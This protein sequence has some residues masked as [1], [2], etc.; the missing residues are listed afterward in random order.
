MLPQWSHGQRRD[1]PALRPR[2]RALPASAGARR[3]RRAPARRRREPLRRAAAA[4]GAGAQPAQA[5]RQRARGDRRGRSP[6]SSRRSRAL[7]LVLPKLKLLTTSGTALVSVAA[8]SLFWGWEFAAGFVVLLFLH[9]MGHVIAL[10]REGIKASAPMFIP[11]LGAAIF[12][13]SL[14]DNALAEARVG[15]AGP[16]LGTPRRGRGRR[17]RRAHRQ[18]VPARAGLRRL[19]HQPVQPAAGRAARRRAGDGGDGAVDVV[20]RLRRAGRDG[21]HLPEPDPADHRAVRRHGD[22]AA[23]AAAQNALARAGRLLPRVAPPPAA[24]RAPSTSA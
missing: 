19:P 14:G 3:A 12:A 16:I 24:R 4:G 11:F 15:L 23:L 21:V 1:F 7:L 2:D 10:R 5:D 18:L 8:Y 20:H 13:K 17:R 6:S 22:L 9:E